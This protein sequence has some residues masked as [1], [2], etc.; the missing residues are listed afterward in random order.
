MIEISNAIL[1]NKIAQLS[2]KLTAQREL[3]EGLVAHNSL[4]DGRLCQLARR[5]QD[6]GVR[7]PNWTLDY[8]AVER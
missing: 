3:E 8:A 6:K 4:L 7:L 2:F 1:Q 5:Y